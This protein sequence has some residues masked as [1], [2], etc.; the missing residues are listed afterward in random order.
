MVEM[1]AGQS[2]PSTLTHQTLF[3]LTKDTRNM[4]NILLEYMM[5]ELS[6]RDFLLLSNPSECKKYVLFMANNLYQHFYELQIVP[7]KD[8]SGVLV[9][10]PAAELT[11]PDDEAAK[12]EK[13][14]L[15]LI[16]AFYYT[17]IFQIY[18]ALAL[19][20]L[21][22][23]NVAA[24][25]GM[26]RVA[27]R[28][29]RRRLLAPGQ[30]AYLASAGAYESVLSLGNFD[31]LSGYIKRSGD[32]F[33]T[34]YKGEGSGKASIYFKRV[35]SSD[36]KEVQQGIF[37]ILYGGKTLATLDAY[38]AKKGRDKEA[39]TI[40]FQLTLYDKKR[41]TVSKSA[42]IPEEIL[43]TNVIDIV[44]FGE[45]RSIHYYVS[46]S[47]QTAPQF[48]DAFFE[49]LVPFIKSK[50][51]DTE[52][53]V[54]T[55]SMEGLRLDRTIQNLTKTKPLGHCIARALQLLQTDP[56]D[57]KKKMSSICEAKFL[58]VTR[59]TAKGTK[60]EVTRSGI[61]S[62]GDSLSESPGMTALSQLFYDIVEQGTP[63]LGVGQ[64]SM[65]EYLLFMRNL[66]IL[67]GDN[68]DPTNPGQPRSAE[69]LVETGLKGL[70][71]RRDKG[72]CIG[73]SG[74]I[75]VAASTSALVSRYVNKL[76]QLQLEHATKCGAIFQKLFSI[77]RDPS[78]NR[79]QIAL[80]DNIIKKGFPEIQR[81]N[82]E[83]RTLL[84]QY[85]TNCEKTYLYGMNEVLA[86]KHAAT[87]Q[88]HTPS[89]APTAPIPTK[90]KA[91]PIKRRA[92]TAP[93]KPITPVPVPS[94]PSL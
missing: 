94:A 24:D 17:R 82:A 11:S 89:T 12:Q 4:M 53:Y 58:H 47:N 42:S 56:F 37:R 92:T 54:E 23:M 10:R 64:S 88:A 86:S 29:A 70:K 55:S 30:Q 39:V 79:L 68:K 33:L 22:D 31:F 91:A 16:L 83:A 9:F 87:K 60:T 59:T 35:P 71:N 62:P 38:A 27:S 1:G 36:N 80:N 61:P 51:E 49:K 76:F 75:P 69:N 74:K 32:G 41:D 19:T 48:L 81:I 77:R 6:V 15:C 46:P 67:Y 50:M 18:G 40:E 7:T 72:L 25:T 43:P 45:G 13:Q 63:H 26:I 73:T 90:P 8:K 14:G 52:T 3:D 34:N 65:K 85:Y 66:A 28:D 2:I 84:V 78:T 20:L 21:D 5:K 93:S 44:S 57:D